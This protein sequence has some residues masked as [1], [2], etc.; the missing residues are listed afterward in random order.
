MNATLP[1]LGRRFGPRGHVLFVCI[2]NSARSQMAEAFLNDMCTGDF[3]AES[4]GMEPGDLSP[5]AV[6]TMR[7]VGID[8]SGK[9]TQGVFDLFKAGRLHSH[10]ITVCDEASAEACPIFPGV[11]ERLH[12]SIPDPATLEGTWEVRLAGIRPIRDAIRNEVEKFCH[13]LCTR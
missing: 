6:Q 4:A 12:W 5:L 7:E 9:S 2:R 11:V 10:V 1:P 8:I 13:A 3:V